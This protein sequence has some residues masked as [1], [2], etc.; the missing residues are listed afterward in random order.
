MISDQ[1]SRISNSI[2]NFLYGI[3]S[4]LVT[5]ILNFLVRTFF[6]KY[7]SIEYLGINGLFTNVLTV[8]SLAE[9]GFGTAMVY[10]M[11][12]PLATKSIREL[13]ALMNLYRKVYVVIGLIVLL[14]GLS[15]VPF[16]DYIIKDTSAIDN[17]QGI[18]LIFLANSVVSYFF[19]YKQ[20]VLHADQKSYICS[21]YR[22]LFAFVKSVLQIISLVLFE[23]FIL[24]LFIQV[25]LTILENMFLCLMVNRMYP[26]LKYSN[27]EKVEKEELYRIKKDVKALVLSKISFVILKGTSNI[28]ISMTAGVVWVG[29]YSNYILITG[30]VI[31]V[32]SQL[33]TA[34]T[35][36]IGNFVTKESKER[37]YELF[38]KVDFMNFWLYGFSTICLVVLFNPFISLWIGDEYT[39]SFACVA[40]ISINF[41]LEGFLNS[42]WT[43]RTTMG[44]FTQG[45]YRPLFSAFINI[46][47]SIFL[48][49][50]Y[51]LI[52]V[53]LGTT[54]SRLFVNVWF[55]PY[56]IFKYGFDK[57]VF[58]YYIRYIKRLLLIVIVVSLL[59]LFDI[60][61]LK[62]SVSIASFCLLTI[63]VF[64]FTNSM[65]FLFYRKEKECVYFVD[66]I[67]KNVSK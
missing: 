39:L 58:N 36:S 52:G 54:F 1:E 46:A 6:I 66:L 55:D 44:L 11:Y 47:I 34:I 61:I 48:G 51:G 24:F 32:L 64:V 3:I 15:V 21:K 9:L 5:L 13:Q 29:Y 22:F 50:K 2:R 31:M 33:S 57:K 59:M 18:Y 23:S 26:F 65:F 30:A 56:V 60:L 53:L 4:Q 8:L 7:L 41:M 14:L 25:L 12:K 45:K 63:V 40:I 37:H 43:F 10:S 27:K 67:K 28:I 17:I 20:S 35:G 49:Y 16:L 38:K 19:A 62:S 42:L